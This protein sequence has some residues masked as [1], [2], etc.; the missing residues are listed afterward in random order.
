MYR[1]EVELKQAFLGGFKLL[2]HVYNNA[3]TS[4]LIEQSIQR[5]EA[6]LASNGALVAY[7]GK[8]TGRSPKDRFIVRGPKTEQNVQWGA[9]NQ[10]VSQSTFEAL[11]KRVLKHLESRDVFVLDARA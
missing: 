3:A 8:R 11:R 5:G 1:R 2:G 4:F 6:K 10:P 7:T 9:V